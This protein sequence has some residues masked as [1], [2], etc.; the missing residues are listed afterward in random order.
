MH[1]PRILKGYTKLVHTVDIPHM[2]VV[3]NFDA[4]AQASDFRIERVKLSSSAEC[5]YEGQGQAII[6]HSVCGM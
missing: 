3:V 5:K 4:L 1:I 6:S 2:S